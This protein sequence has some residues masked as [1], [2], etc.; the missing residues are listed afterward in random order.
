[1]P[2]V[3]ETI[4]LYCD[5]GCEFKPAH[6]RPG[7]QDL[8]QH[9]PYLLRY[10]LLR[11]RYGELAEDMG[12]ETLLAAIEGSAGF[13]GNSSRMTWRTGILKRKIVDAMRRNF[14]F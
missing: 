6:E 3:A 10:A 13:A 1:M 2:C 4:Y 14:P 5:I 11:R 7:N 9:R 12:Q 8:Q